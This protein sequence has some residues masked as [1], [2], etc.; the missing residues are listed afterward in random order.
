MK[1]QSDAAKENAKTAANNMAAIERLVEE[2][3]F[4]MVASILKG[5][6]DQL[7]NSILHDEMSP[8]VR[9]ELRHLRLGILEALRTPH[10]IHEGAA[11]VLRANSQ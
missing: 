11:S 9:E 3:G 7:A 8:V 1:Q 5:R 2:E 4:K 10:E 6:A